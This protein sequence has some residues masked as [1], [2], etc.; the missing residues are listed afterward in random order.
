MLFCE[1]DSK[2]NLLQKL[3]TDFSKKI[4]YYT[5]GRNTARLVT[6]HN[7]Y[8]FL[9]GFREYPIHVKY[10]YGMDEKFT[11]QVNRILNSPFSQNMCYKYIEKNNLDIHAILIIDTRKVKLCLPSSVLCYDSSENII[12]LQSYKEVLNKQY[13]STILDIGFPISEL[14][15]YH[16]QKIESSEKREKPIDIQYEDSG[17]VIQF[18]IKEEEKRVVLCKKR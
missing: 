4:G 17:N 11:H 12:D 15:P 2:Q 14:N 1:Y 6:D 16:I 3:G 7:E 10:D 8:Y 5:Y 18:D 13:L 9:C